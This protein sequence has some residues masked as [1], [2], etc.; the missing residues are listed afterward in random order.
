MIDPAVPIVKKMVT[1][2]VAEA[3]DRYRS[4]YSPIEDD[5][6]WPAMMQS[7]IVY[8]VLWALKRLSNV[9]VSQDG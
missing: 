2:A 4:Y 3:V 9:E 7:E 8:E 5:A 1:K 6:D